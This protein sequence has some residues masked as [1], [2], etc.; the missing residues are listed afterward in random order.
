MRCQQDDRVY[1]V[2]HHDECIDMNV[3]V[4]R[5]KC[6]QFMGHVRAERRVLDAIGRD[7]PEGV[8]TLMRHDRHEVCA[9]VGVVESVKACLPS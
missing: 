3:L 1:V 8:S 9:A 7:L 4:M 5:R 2:R 6:A